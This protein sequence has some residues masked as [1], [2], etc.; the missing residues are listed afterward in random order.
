MDSPRADERTAAQ[1]PGPHPGKAARLAAR[2]LDASC[3]HAVWELERRCFSLPWSEAQ[4]RAAFGQPAFAAFGLWSAEALVAYISLYHAGAPADASYPPCGELEI[5][6]LAVAPAARRQGC[7]RRLL[8]LA[9]QAGRKVGMQKA[10]LEVREGNH[11][12]LALYRTCGFVQVGRR[13]RYYADTGEDALVLERPLAE[14][15]PRAPACARPITRPQRRAPCR[16]SSP[17][18]GRCTRSARRPERRPP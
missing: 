5:L 14:T 16:R 18:T 7:G 10:I 2:R 4:C 6:N 3:A 8:A 13:R 12:A 11:A 17:P 9:L 1:L 15:A